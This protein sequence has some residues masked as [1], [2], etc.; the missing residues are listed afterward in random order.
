MADDHTVIGRAV[1]ILDVVTDAAG[2]LPLAV[3]TRRTGIPKATVRRIANDLV[4]R[5]MLAR[6]PDGY[7][8][9][10]RL[11]QQGLQSAYQ[12]G[13]TL[14]VQPY[15]QDLHL[16]SRGELAWFATLNGGELTMAGAAFGRPHIATM[17]VSWW[18]GMAALGPSM[19]LLASG[20][21]QLAHQP[22]RAEAV[23][24]SGWRPLTR[25]SVVDRRR[26]R[27]LL[28]R[29][30]ETGFAREDEQSV[31]GW[32][33]LAT[34]LRDRDGALVGALGITGRG[35]HLEAR[36]LP[37]EL[38]RAARSLEVELGSAAAAADDRPWDTPVFH[39][40]TGIGYSWPTVNA[41]GPDEPNLPAKPSA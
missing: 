23:L 21:L 19:V 33:C 13:R 17:R 14:A 5:D 22:E 25:Y 16:H 32:S 3:L 40:R 15:L 35:P 12:N 4:E 26:M 41:P 6:T 30:R 10:Q 9:G 11:I 18:P 38:R 28:T 34:V 27:D 39:R 29:A 36:G 20:R 2:P 31:L 24:A 7:T 1:A 37:G 8:A